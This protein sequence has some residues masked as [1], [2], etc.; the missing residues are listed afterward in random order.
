MDAEDNLANLRVASFSYYLKPSEE[1]FVQQISNHHIDDPPLPTILSSQ[2][3]SSFPIAPGRKISSH[4]INMM[5]SS[6]DNNNLSNHHRVAASTASFSPRNLK[7]NVQENFVFT[8]KAPVHQDLNAAMLF[9]RVSPTHVER[10]PGSRN[11][12][13]GVFG[14]DKYFNMRL[15][16]ATRMKNV[17]NRNEEVAVVDVM[18]K[19]NPIRPAGSAPS[20]SS[21]EVSSWNSQAALLGT[22]NVSRTRP[23]R[24][25]GRRILASFVCSGPCLE[26]GAIFVSDNRKGDDGIA[27]GEKG[28]S[29][30]QPGGGSKR[31]DN[32]INNTSTNHFAFPILNN[33]E[34]Q[35]QNLNVQ[36]NNKQLDDH[37]NEKMLDDQ[38]RPSLEVFG[39]ER[40]RKE[41][42]VATNLA[43]KL[44]MLT[45]DAI[46]KASS[47]LPTTT[48]TLG[49]IST[50][51]ACDD[52]T[53]D[54]S[55]DLFEIED[56]SKGGAA[57]G[58]YQILGTMEVAAL[59]NMSAG[60]MSPPTPYA[61]SEASIEWS[62][63]TASAADFS[64]V[65][66]DYDEKN[67]VSSSVHETIPPN[68]V[69]ENARSKNPI[70]KDAQKIRPGG[71]LGCKSQKT[72]NVAETVHKTRVESYR[73]HS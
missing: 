25:I 13:I 41:G 10:V 49:I 17:E 32:N 71:L 16:C 14:A 62:V 37:D 26:K 42:D 63:V 24:T 30:H 20:I 40:M 66:S 45:W 19:S 31:V 28:T 54:A 46:P 38:A 48:N 15:D 36:K 47:N 53:S 39:S 34:G 23:R 9:P 50:T 29:S 61:P 69:N 58:G 8:V 22:Q 4:P 65:I 12:E 1:N 44:S 72:V 21:S 60:C 27:Y 51:T 52:M 43:R 35:A 64:S 11:G 67:V 57:G 6:Q 2:E 73:F 70:T 68:T 7:D 33:S 3:T 56:I 59:D 55:S 5:I 18:K